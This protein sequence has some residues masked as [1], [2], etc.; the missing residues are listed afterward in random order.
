MRRKKKNSWNAMRKARKRKGK[1]V[2][3]AIV[4]FDLHFV[5]RI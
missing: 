3:S 2:I 1:A 5:S 4:S